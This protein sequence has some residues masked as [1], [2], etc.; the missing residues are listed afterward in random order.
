[1]LGR[2]DETEV[3]ESLLRHVAEGRGGGVI[4]QGEPGIG[5]TALLSYIEE[6]ATGF[7]VL[8]AVGVAPESGFAYATLHQLLLPVLGLVDGLPGPQARAM[9][10]LFGRAH[11]APPDPFLVALSVLSLLSLL[12]DRQPVLCVVD[13]AHWADQPT[14]KTLAFVARRLDNE[15][16]ALVLAARVD[17][18]H[19]ID[20]PDLRRVPL[21]GLDREAAKALL[22]ERFGERR[23]TES[24]LNHLLAATG[25]NP[26]ALIELAGSR[27]PPEGTH[28]PPAMTDELQRS[29]LTKVRARH[30]E[31]LPLLQLIAADGSG[32]T[33]VIE[34]AAAS[35]RVDIGP[36]HR[37]ELDELLTHDGPRLVFRHPLIRSAI[38]HSATADRQAAI[39]R[40]LASAFDDPADQHRRAWHLGQAAVDH[41]EQAAEQLERSA[42]QAALRGG[43]A[44]AMAALSRAAE[45]TADGPRRGRRLWTAAHAALHGGFTAK[46]EELLD[47]AEREPHLKEEDRIPLAVM[48]AI[49]AVFAGSPEDALDLIRPWMPRA[50]HLDRRRF[51]PTVAM[52]GDLGIRAL[53]PQAWSD[54]GGWLEEITPAPDDPEEAVL[55]LLR[56][57][58]RARTGR[59]PEPAVRDTAV[60][61]SLTDPI[62]MTLAGAV[63]RGLG[64]HELG[65]RLYRD[66]G[67][68]ARTSGSLG[69][70]AWNLEYQAADEI[71]RGRYGLAEAHAEEGCQFATEVGQSSTACRNRGLLAFCAAVRGRPDAG[72]LATE[73][74]AEGSDRRLA[75]AMSYAWRALGLIELGAGR[76]REAVRHFEAVGAWDIDAPADLV[77]GTVPDLVE[78]LVRAGERDRAAAATARYAQWSRHTAAPELGALAARCRALTCTD[79][80]ADVHYAESLRLHASS[81]SPLEQARTELLFGEWLRRDRRRSQAQRHL[82]GAAETFRRIGALAWADRA[83]GELRAT[84]ESVRA[85]E[86]GALSSLTPQELRITLAVGEGLTNREIAAQLFLSPRTVDYHLRKVFQKADITSRA[87]LMRL[88]LTESPAGYQT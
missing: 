33:D 71:A 16:V 86:A 30:T 75:D 83:L 55:L 34:K 11:G 85:P 88:V 76:Y 26:L 63:A 31:S 3:L 21:M 22:A 68:L 79:G 65:R 53:R 64:E 81:D 10:I 45:L 72:E 59:D 49:V 69:A 6:R 56:R 42:E 54:L 39:H 7:Q 24:A 44:A 27:I 17:E 60:L 41:D 73:V 9:N 61:G 84:G 20:L 82:R 48:R 28:E 15:P 78:A 40:A 51:A 38:H 66:A 62:T 74:L 43:P 58:C 19:G 23:L 35:L 5:K 52:Y 37:G 25:G 1:M 47:R 70:L 36:L 8:R 87:E 18:G 67:R 13:D 14:L 12:A 80:A 50:L 2:D 57:A 77:M 29:F 4:L 46:A 32:S